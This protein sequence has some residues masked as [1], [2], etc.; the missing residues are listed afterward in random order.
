MAT[1][2]QLSPAY[3]SHKSLETFF[4]QRRED[5]HVTDVVDKSLMTNFSGATANELVSALKF[6]RLINDKGEPSPRYKEYVLADEERRKQL[7]GDILRDAYPW[8]FDTSKFNIERAT[9]AQFAELFRQQG[10]TGSTLARGIAFF[11]GMAKYAGIKVSPNVKVPPGLRSS[12]SS[13]P[14]KPKEGANTVSATNDDDGG[15]DDGGDDSGVMKFEIP[16]PVDR[17]VRITIPADFNAADW[18]L[19][20]TMFTAYVTRWQAM[21]GQKDKGPTPA[22]E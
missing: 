2:K 4:N 10:P 7:M 6:L 12:S 16:I 3:V 19:L 14:K 20:Q 17:K 8:L 18:T 15:G 21:E 5:G 11:L 9:A 22:K 13:K 1:E